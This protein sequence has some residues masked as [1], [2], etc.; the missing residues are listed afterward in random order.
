MQTYLI[1][2]S[3][4]MLSV[5]AQFALRR[6]ALSLSHELSA[7]PVAVGRLLLGA[8]TNLPLLLGFALYFAGAVLWL[9]VLSRWEVSKAY[10]LVGLGF[11]LTAMIG[12]AIGESVTSQRVLGVVAV[13]VGVWL[14][15]RS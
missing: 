1:V 5:L 10:P 8:A 2:I 11:V 15:G 7:Q 13:C 3:S 12:W 6:G 4:V 9:V 14:V